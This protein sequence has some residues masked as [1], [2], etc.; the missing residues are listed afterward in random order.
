MGAPRERVVATLDFLE[1]IL[2]D[3]MIFCHCTGQAVMSEMSELFK[4][5]VL[6]GQTGLVMNV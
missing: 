6:T 5:R 4:E 1:E 2:P 3:R